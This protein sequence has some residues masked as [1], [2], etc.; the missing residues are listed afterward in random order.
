VLAAVSEWTSTTLLSLAVRLRHARAPSTSSSPTF[1]G[2]RSRSISS[3]PSSAECYPML[4]LLRTRRSASRSSAT[5]G[6]SA[7]A[8]S[9]TG[10]LIPTCTTSCWRSSRRSASCSRRR[11]VAR[12][13]SRATRASAA[14]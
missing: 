14:R 9:P 13:L 3:A 12:R 6:S 10:T 8:S 4:A 11:G 1:Q 2:R 5:P 7:G